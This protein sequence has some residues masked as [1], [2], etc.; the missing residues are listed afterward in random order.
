M[1]E[2]AVALATRAP[3]LFN[4]QPW[5]WQV[6]TESL[7]LLLDRSRGIP[8]TDPVFREL[9]ISCGPRYITPSSP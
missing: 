7:H 6:G 3:S 5:Q 2:A 9:T 8:V 1:L 4:V